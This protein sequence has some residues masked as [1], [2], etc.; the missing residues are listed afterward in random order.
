MDLLPDPGMTIDSLEGGDSGLVRGTRGLMTLAEDGVTTIPTI[1]DTVDAKGIR[2][3]GR[4]IPMAGALRVR[5]LVA[6][7]EAGEAGVGDVPQGP[8][9]SGAATN[10]ANPV[11]LS[12]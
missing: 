11:R 2:T 10:L 8:L 3:Q 1:T 6:R 5:A 9:K 12:M 7:V 4:V